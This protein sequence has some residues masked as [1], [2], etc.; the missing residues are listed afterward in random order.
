MFT[1][2]KDLPRLKEVEELCTQWR[3][4]SNDMSSKNDLK[5]FLRT[6]LGGTFHCTPYIDVIDKH[7]GILK[8]H[9]E[10]VPKAEA[11]KADADAEA[12]EGANGLKLCE[13]YVQ[14]NPNSTPSIK[15]I[16]KFLF[17]QGFA[18]QST[19]LLRINALLKTC[20]QI[21]AKK[22]KQMENV[23][24]DSLFGKKHKHQ[25]DANANPAKRKGFFGF[26]LF[27]DEDK[28]EADANPAKRKTKSQQKKRL[29]TPLKRKNKE[30]IQV[31]ARIENEETAELA[32]QIQKL[33]NDLNLGLTCHG[34]S[35]AQNG[36]QDK[37]VGILF[38]ICTKRKLST[39][40]H[41]TIWENTPAEEAAQ[42]A[43][44]PEKDLGELKVDLKE[45]ELKDITTILGPYQLALRVGSGHICSFE[46]VIEFM[47][48]LKAEYPQRKQ[49]GID[50]VKCLLLLMVA[51]RLKKAFSLHEPIEKTSVDKL[52]SKCEKKEWFLWLN[53]ISRKLQTVFSV[54]KKF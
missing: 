6:K 1:I 36:F 8:A 37:F 16:M 22:T 27:D 42:N 49:S 40:A 11:P 5:K 35:V 12:L 3:Q 20:Q 17:T 32:A 53:D 13:T 14:N 25:N 26:G 46:S 51:D 47:G 9:F 24:T 23:A 50:L 19:V 39:K 10:A 30:D 29:Y 33:V 48:K 28:A 7:V 21:V 31:I 2:T 4:D 54:M 44:F 15:G 18:N 52:V 41:P 43:K 38:Y 45:D 34:V